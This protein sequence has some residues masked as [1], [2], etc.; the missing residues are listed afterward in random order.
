[1]QNKK[2][3]TRPKKS[4]QFY[5]IN[6][7][8]NHTRYIIEDKILEIMFAQFRSLN[9][10]IFEKYTTPC[11]WQRKGDR[12][13][14]ERHVLSKIGKQAYIKDNISRY[15][16]K[17]IQALDTL[18]KAKSSQVMSDHQSAVDWYIYT[19]GIEKIT[20]CDNPE[21]SDQSVAQQVYSRM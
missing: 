8:K 3:Y 11:E 18:E 20:K 10:L 4:S 19:K 12:I 2:Y 6:Y 13:L 17:Y 15:G 1:M 9:E 16:P 21:D 5:I 14:S 7:K